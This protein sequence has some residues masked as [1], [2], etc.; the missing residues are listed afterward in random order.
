M[1]DSQARHQAPLF[2][3]PPTV[4]GALSSRRREYTSLCCPLCESKMQA[5]PLHSFDDVQAAAHFCPVARDIDRHHRMRA[6]INKIW[7]TKNAEVYVCPECG[8][9]FGWPYVG[10]D[11][12]FYSIL[13]E[14]AGYPSSRWEYDLTIEQVNREFP[15]GGKILDISAGDGIFLKSLNDKWEKSGSET[16]RAALRA[17]GIACHRGLAEVVGDSKGSFELVAVRVL[18]SDTRRFPRGIVVCGETLIRCRRARDP[19]DSHR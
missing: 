16:M 13:A 11:E 3:L 15:N 7:G 6:S 19:I 4:D 8:F 1:S 2:D 18:D 14:H 5:P 17:A 12:E 10:G 9:G